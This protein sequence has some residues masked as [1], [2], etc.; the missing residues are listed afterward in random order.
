MTGTSG[1]LRGSEDFSTVAYDAATGKTRWAEAYN[2]PADDTDLGG[3]VAVSPDGSTVF[4]A[5]LSTGS[6][7]RGDYA[8][9]AY[10]TST[11]A[12]LW[13]QRYNGV[14]THGGDSP[15]DLAVSPDGSAVFVTGTSEGVRFTDYAT[16]AYAVS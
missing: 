16:V 3:A 15:A 6:T 7:T 11:G 14:V 5:G 4:V 9:L 1:R 12:M 8:T 10:E 2:G 13:V